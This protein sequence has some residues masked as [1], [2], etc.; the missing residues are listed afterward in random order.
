MNTGNRTIL[1]CSCKNGGETLLAEKQDF[2]K[3]EN[4]AQKRL[5][6]NWF[7]GDIPFG[8]C[9]SEMSNCD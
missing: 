7:N 8:W 6:Q 9:I 1:F 3:R 2:E 5:S 4:G